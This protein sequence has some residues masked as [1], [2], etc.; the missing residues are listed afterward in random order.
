MTWTP[1]VLLH[2]L[3]AFENRFQPWRI[4]FALL[5]HP[6]NYEAESLSNL[7]SCYIEM[8]P[9][10]VSS[11]LIVRKRISRYIQMELIWKWITYCRLV[12]V[13]S[14]CQV[15]RIKF[16]WDHDSGVRKSEII[17]LGMYMAEIDVSFGRNLFG[18]WFRWSSFH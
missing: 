10:P 13:T 9:G 14:T 16:R 15:T 2:C 17:L 1:L 5:V 18:E 11:I 3:L 6:L 4:E 7:C 12:M 8:K